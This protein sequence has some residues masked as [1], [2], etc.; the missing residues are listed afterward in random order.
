MP[1][2]VH[3]GRERIQVQPAG[4]LDDD[5]VEQAVETD[6]AG[7]MAMPAV[8]AGSSRRRPWPP[9]GS[10]DAVDSTRS[11]PDGTSPAPG[12]AATGYRSFPGSQLSGPRSRAYVHPGVHGSRRPR[13]RHR[14]RDASGA[15]R[16]R[17]RASSKPR[18]GGG[19]IHGSQQACGRVAAGARRDHGQPLSSSGDGPGD[20]RQHPVAADRHHDRAAPHSGHAT[21]GSG[22]RRRTSCR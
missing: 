22:S 3:L 21:P 13:T 12:P 10:S 19:V 5:H 6:A 11:P 4:G 20:R 17:S 14:A 15:G 7:A 9:G 1:A 2:V 8:V 18:L 16:C